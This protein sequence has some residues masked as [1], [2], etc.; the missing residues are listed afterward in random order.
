MSESTDL[1]CRELVELV[2][3]YLE[4]V[5]LPAERRRVEE[6]LAGCP[7]CTAYLEQMRTAIE[8]T[9]RVDQGVELPP[10]EVRQALLS[11]FRAWKSGGSPPAAGR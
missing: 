7:G 3:D 10:P 4:G 11:A 5:M 6:H 2:T 1:S 8:L 9:G